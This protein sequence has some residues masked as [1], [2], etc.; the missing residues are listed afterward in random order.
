M[1][2]FFFVAGKGTGYR[3]A[4]KDKSPFVYAKGLSI[5]SEI[6]YANLTSAIT[7]LKLLFDINLSY[8]FIILSNSKQKAEVEITSAFFICCNQNFY[9]LE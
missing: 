1:K 3:L 7:S 5:Y 9:L 6:L 4:A 8:S 2:S